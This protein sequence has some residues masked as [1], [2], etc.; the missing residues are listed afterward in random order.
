MTHRN[1]VLETIRYVR[2]YLLSLKETGVAE[3]EATVPTKGQGSP[4]PHSFDFSQDRLNPLPEGEEIPLPFKGRD[5]VGMGFS[6]ETPAQKPQQLETL[7]KHIGDCHRCKLWEGRT[8]IVF[9]TGSP[10]AALMFVGEGPGQE[11]DRQGKPFVG[12]AGDLLTKMIAAMGL[13]RDNVYIANVIKCRPPGNRN[14]E[15][16]EIAA[17]KPF[18][19]EQIDIIKP[20]IICA[21]GTFAAQTLLDTKT[22]ISDLREKIHERGGYKIVATFHPAYLLRNPNEK[23]RAWEDLQIVMKELGLVGE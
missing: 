15:E 11:E 17:C 1:E 10:D 18:L 2:E 8:N 16:D 5:R 3:I 9:G 20:K 12:R 6:D 7:R 4:H 14:P 13:T 23:R 19:N 22:R 21:L